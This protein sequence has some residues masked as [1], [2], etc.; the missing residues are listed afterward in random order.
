MLYIIFQK[1]GSNP[2]VLIGEEGMQRTDLY[3]DVYTDNYLPSFFN[4]FIRVLVNYF[5]LLGCVNTHHTNWLIFND[6]IKSG[7]KDSAMGRCSYLTFSLS[8]V[9][10]NMQG[11]EIEFS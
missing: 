9:Y 5:L 6:P 10:S 11:E 3:T 1:S 8:S 4:D 2:A 7:H